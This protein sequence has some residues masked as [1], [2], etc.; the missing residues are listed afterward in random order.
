MRL[1]SLINYCDSYAAGSFNTAVYTGLFRVSGPA[2]LLASTK[3]EL[4][5]TTDED[6]VLSLLEKVY[7]E[8]TDKEDSVNTIASL[9]KW[10]VS[11]FPVSLVSFEYGI[12]D[13]S[14]A[15]YE[16]VAD[17]DEKGQRGCQLAQSLIIQMAG[18]LAAY[19]IKV[20][21]EAICV[22]A[23]LLSMLCTV[24]RVEDI[25]MPAYNLCVPFLPSLCGSK[26]PMDLMKQ[27]T[28]LKELNE[29]RRAAEA[30]GSML[31]LT[32][33]EVL[34]QYGHRI[35]G[36]IEHNLLSLENALKAIEEVTASSTVEVETKRRKRDILK[37]MLAK[38]K[39]SP[40]KDRNTKKKNHH[41]GRLLKRLFHKK[42]SDNEGT[43]QSKEETNRTTEEPNSDA[44]L[45]NLSIIEHANAIGKDDLKRLAIDR[46]DSVRLI[47]PVVSPIANE[48][49]CKEDQD[50]DSSDDGA[51][52]VEDLHHTATRDQS[53]GVK[54]VELLRALVSSDANSIERAKTSRTDSSDLKMVSS[55]DPVRRFGSS[56]T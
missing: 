15:G 38:M 5:A 27:L 13:M 40:F 16:S 35:W 21:A 6:S 18:R 43:I 14:G 32:R 25:K 26:D 36:Y 28:E 1:R 22:T 54:G 41:H 48:P 42:Q 11:E 53:L 7:A 9:L 34:I 2:D 20:V 33:L 52:A 3:V 46:I 37:R 10:V 47:Q 4:A 55:A 44:N 56:P 49:L 8:R 50:T 39:L 29:R 23:Q 45:G 51:A 24:S 12:K 17:D 30:Q 31:P 19:E